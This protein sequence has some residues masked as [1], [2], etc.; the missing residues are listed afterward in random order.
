MRYCYGCG[1]VTTGEPLFCNTC[2]RSFNLK[3]CPRL[4]VNPRSAAVC[5][6]CGSSDLSTPQPRVPWWSAPLL[7]L[8]TILP[9]AVLWV[10]T[11]AFFLAFLYVLV[12][13]QQLMM[14]FMLIGLLL[15]LVWYAYL[16]LPQVLR[17]GISKLWQRSAKHGREA[18]K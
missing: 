7:W 15:G 10:I 14:L 2:G 5:S 3:L 11:A 4:H 1:R 18:H 9:V 6:Q 8:V 17:K 16:Q 13:D 12:S